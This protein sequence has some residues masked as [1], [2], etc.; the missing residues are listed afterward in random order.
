MDII[1]KRF[2]K[3]EKFWSWVYLVLQG[4]GYRGT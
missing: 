4:I 2:A 3:K 1:L